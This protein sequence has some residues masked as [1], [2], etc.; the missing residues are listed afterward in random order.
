MTHKMTKTDSSAQV[1]T[2]LVAGHATIGPQPDT[3]TASL[4]DGSHTVDVDD[5]S[6]SIESIGP[7]LPQHA[8]GNQ[9]GPTP[10]QNC[11]D[12]DKRLTPKTQEFFLP[13]HGFV[14]LTQRE[15][16]VVNHPTF[17]RLRRT[18]QLGFA[19]VAFPGGTH[20]RFEHSIGAV[21]I[22]D[23]II[24]HINLNFHRNSAEHPSWTLG[25]ITDAEKQLIRLAA[26]LHDIG[27]LP[28][29]HTLEDELG[30]LPPHDDDARLEKV[31]QRLYPDYRPSELVTDGISETDAREW[32]LEEL[33]NTLYKTEVENSLEIACETPFSV[34]QAIISKAP[35]QPEDNEDNPELAVKSKN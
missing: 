15:V 32:T 35:K 29:G 25:E 5:R 21:D 17:Q 18:R 12:G 10:A 6:P 30:H 27:H 20:T 22:A 19:H 23:R 7:I 1:P 31:S 16:E 33:V 14:T 28:F 8:S 26:L 34:L 13:V 4:G 11:S 3:I 9:P 24:S 2:N